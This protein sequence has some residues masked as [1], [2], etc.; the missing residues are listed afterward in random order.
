[1]YYFLIDQRNAIFNER[2]WTLAAREEWDY[3]KETVFIIFEELKER[4]S[5]VG[6][7]E[8]F[9]Y[10]SGESVSIGEWH[11]GEGQV[12][13][14]VGIR[15]IGVIKEKRSLDEP[16]KQKSL[17]E[18]PGALV[19]SMT[20]S[21]TVSVLIYPPRSERK[22]PQWDQYHV[23]VYQ[24]P[25]KI[26]KRRVNKHIKQFIKLSRYGS[27]F[28]KPSKLKG[29][30]VTYFGFKDIRNLEKFKRNIPYF[31]DNWARAIFLALV[32]F[33]VGYSF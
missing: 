5:Q 21:G 16:P 14:H 13:L 18:D 15:P 4:S 6:F 19:F 22:F 29:I 20:A 24:R 30:Y 10:S 28:G 31:L 17:T 32:S 12:Q 8:E 23:A 7:P 11:K 27:V 25:S 1:M 9:F 33:W 26:T 2:R 3:F